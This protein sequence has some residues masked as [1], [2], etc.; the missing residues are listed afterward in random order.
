M[1]GYKRF[2]NRTVNVR[3]VCRVHRNLHT[4]GY[5]VKQK[6]V[7]V[8]HVDEFALV[9]CKFIV[10][11]AGRERVREQKQKNV[12]AF[13]EGKFQPFINYCQS[14]GKTKVKYNPYKD[15]GFV[16]E[17]GQV[18]VEAG[19]VTFSQDGVYAYKPKFRDSE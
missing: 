6:G 9:N 14:V 11:T 17:N 5:S 15:E 2:K 7:V 1:K 4:G 18:L 10:S 16:G 19:A 8:A 12:H 3:E 13:V